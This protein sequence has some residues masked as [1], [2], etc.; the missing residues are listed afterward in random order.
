MSATPHPHGGYYTQDQLRALVAHAASRGITVVPEI[1]LPGHVRA[2]LAAYPEYGIG[3]HPVATS[4]GI[5][6]EVLQ[7]RDDT[8]TMVEQVFAE[9]LDVFPSPWIHIG[10]DE[11]PRDAVAQ[12]PRQRPPRRRPGASSSVDD[13]QRWFTVHLHSWLTAHGRR[14]V[15][16]DEILDDGPVPGAVVMAW[17]DVRYGLD[18]LHQGNEVVMAPGPFTYFDRYQ[19]DDP[20]ERLG[21]PGLITWRDVVSYDPLDGIPADGGVACSASRDSCGAN[22]C[23]TLAKSST[24][25]SPGWPC[26]PRSAWRGRVL[27]DGIEQRLGAHLTRSRRGRRRVPTRSTARIPGNRAAPVAAGGGRPESQST[28]AAGCRPTGGRPR[29]TDPRS[30]A[31]QPRTRRAAATA[32]TTR[33]ARPASPRLAVGQRAEFGRR[34][35]IG[36]GHQIAQVALGHDAVLHAPEHVGDLAE[37][38]RPVRG[39]PQRAGRTPGTHDPLRVERLGGV[40]RRLRHP[41]RVVEAFELSGTRV[42]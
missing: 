10:G 2:L 14:V 27:A 12:R 16:W 4:F 23:T 5:F 30:A 7:L 41:S 29:P 37:R 36:H 21:Q 34:A 8:V 38:V 32:R 1:D 28:G 22:T 42:G 39:I 17:R 20:R 11:C 25:R 15:G 3:R 9:L 33:R 40:S 13:L 6:P 35:V 26:S 31:P 24:W 19:S 18:A